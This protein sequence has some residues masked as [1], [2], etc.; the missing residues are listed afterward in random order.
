MKIIDL[1]IK[2]IGNWKVKYLMQ[3]EKNIYIFKSLEKIIIKKEVFKD[4]KIY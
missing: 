2:Q 1:Q 4:V 3:L